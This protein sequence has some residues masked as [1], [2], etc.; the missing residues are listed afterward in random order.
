MALKSLDE[1]LSNITTAATDLFIE[2]GYK[3]T[4]LKDIALA[5]GVSKAGIYHYFKTKEDI[6]S[7][8]LFRFHKENFAAYEAAKDKLPDPVTDPEKALKF[9]IRTYAQL[10]LRNAKVALLNLRER[11]QLTGS[12]RKNH[13]EE[14][15]R[16]FNILKTSINTIPGINKK[17]DLNAVAFQII[18]MSVW[19]GYWQS[20]KGNLT[21][22]GVIEQHIDIFC[23]GLFR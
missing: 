18:S 16:I 21:Q 4:S 3:P 17:Y 20:E 22:E 1:R 19:T 5:T 8:I 10:S 14:E 23:H 2:K 6:L 12:N 11:H 7:Y 13:L 15:R 9:I